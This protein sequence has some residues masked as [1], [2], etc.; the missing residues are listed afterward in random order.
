MHARAGSRAAYRPVVSALLPSGDA[1]PVA[2]AAAYREVVHARRCYVALLDAIGGAAPDLAMLGRLSGPGAFDAPLL[3]DA[4]VRSVAEAQ[5]IQASGNQVVVG[6]ETMGD[7]GLLSRLA[8]LGPTVFSLDLRRG[9]PL[10]PAAL[11]GDAR[12][13][14][15][16]SLARAAAEAGVVGV[17]VLDLAR[18]GTGQG[19]DPGLLGAIRGAAR[20]IELLAGGGIRPAD[21]PGLAGAGVD[22]VLLATALH[23]GWLPALA[24]LPARDAE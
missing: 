12:T 20:D 8:A 22:A 7:L 13:R 18:V 9:V 11:A 4:G 19:P 23:E 10:V 2:L 1:D 6:L 24:Q 15:A 16:V 17:I 5:A 3:V 21:L 14:D